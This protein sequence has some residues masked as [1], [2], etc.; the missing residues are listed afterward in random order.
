MIRVTCAPALDVFDESVRQPGLTWL[1]SNKIDPE[2]PPP[3]PGALPAYWQAVSKELWDAYEGV[4]AYLAIYFEWPLGAHSTDHFVAKSRAAGLA[5]EWSN[6]RLSC[7]GANRRKNRFDDILD[8]FELEPDTFEL[9]LLSGEIRSNPAK[10]SATTERAQ[11]TI[12]RLRL[13]GPEEKRMRARHYREYLQHDVSEAYLKRHSPF[14]WY[15]ARR[16]NLL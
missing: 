9:N 7:L 5:Y 3:D 14:V 11:A 10:S 2:L 6:Y 8:P 13:N 4:C 1:R 15:E 12:D 16:Q